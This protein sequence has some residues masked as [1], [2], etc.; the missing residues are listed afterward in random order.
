MM[1]RMHWR[2][3]TIQIL[4]AGQSDWSTARTAA[5]EMGAEETQVEFLFPLCEHEQWFKDSR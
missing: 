2:T 4:K 1:L 5:G 3:S